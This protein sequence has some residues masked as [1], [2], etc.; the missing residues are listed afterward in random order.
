VEFDNFEIYVADTRRRFAD[1]KVHF[2]HH[3]CQPAQLIQ[4]EHSGSAFRAAVREREGSAV[5]YAIRVA[6]HIAI[7]TFCDSPKFASINHAN[8]HSPTGGWGRTK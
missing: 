3:D 5:I 6:Y 4:Q 1:E 8:S 2:F 7:R